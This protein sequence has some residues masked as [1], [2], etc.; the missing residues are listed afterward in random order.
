MAA[1]RTLVYENQRGWRYYWRE[2]DA[3]AHLVRATPGAQDLRA[4]CVA[5]MTAGAPPRGSISCRWTPDLFQESEARLAAVYDAA[6][7]ELRYMR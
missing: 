3:F 6:R 1:L 5:L 2:G 7:G 4:E